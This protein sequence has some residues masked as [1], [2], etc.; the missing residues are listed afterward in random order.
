MPLVRNLPGFVRF[1]PVAA[2]FHGQTVNTSALA[3]DAGVARTTV[4]GYLEILQDTFLATVLPAYQARLRVRE[5]KH[6]KLYWVDSGLVRAVKRQ[7]GP[8]V[9]EETGP[10]IESWI[11]MLL[12][13]YAEDRDLYEDIFSW[14]PLQAKRT[15]VDFLL[16]RGRELL[17]LEVKSARRFSSSLLSGLRAIGESEAVV[18]RVLV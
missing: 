9:S 4:A 8:V 6:P 13:A 15:E 12:R 2:L 1:L 5:R 17:A 14:A 18:R 10:L 3:R 16:R 7:L 11:F